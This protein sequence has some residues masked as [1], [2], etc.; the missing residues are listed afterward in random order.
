MKAWGKQEITKRRGGG[1]GPLD[2]NWQLPGAGDGLHDDVG[3]LH[4]AGEQL[5]LGPLQQRLD[6][7]LVP[8]G[9]HDANAQGA[10][11]ML[12]GCGGFDRHGGTRE[13]VRYIAVG[14]SELF[15]CGVSTRSCV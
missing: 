4:A 9:V 12:L 14:K 6:D 2:G 1:Y 13:L 5:G 8:P 7:G 15:F 11:V 10:A 3:L